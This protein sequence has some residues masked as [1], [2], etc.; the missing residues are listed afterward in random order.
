VG[1]RLSKDFMVVRGREKC[2]KIKVFQI[3]CPLQLVIVVIKTW[4]KCGHAHIIT[5][6]QKKRDYSRFI[7]YTFSVCLDP[8]DENTS[9]V[10][11]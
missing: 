1:V 2:D 10:S 3:G 7:L 5:S 11:R 9:L 4:S 6:K 8:Q